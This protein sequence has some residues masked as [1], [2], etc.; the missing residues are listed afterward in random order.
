LSI[1]LILRDPSKGQA[2]NVAG[3]TEATQP[4]PFLKWAGGKRGLLDEIAKRTPFF[5]G[6]YIEPF[7]G[8]GAVFFTQQALRKKVVSDFNSDLMEVYEV[9]RDE[10][11]KL[12]NELRKHRNTSEHFY[13]V[14]DWD[15]RASF[16][17]RSRIGRAA[18]FIFL[19]KTAYNGLYRVNRSGQHNVPFAGQMNPDWV[20]EETIRNVSAFLNTRDL[21]GA[22]TSLLISGDYR[23]SL[24]YATPDS[25]VYLDPP[26]AENFSDYQSEGFTAQD[27]VD[28]RDAVVELTKNKVPFLLSNSDVKQIWDIYQEPKG[29]FQI[30][31]VNVR[32]AIGSKVSSR[33]VISELMINNYKAVGAKLDNLQ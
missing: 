24:S 4:Q 23:D 33:G 2:A 31:K 8:A 27:Q 16:K 11:E 7:L 15:R 19:N 20:Q 30:E 21:S 29:L 12:I 10:P 28:L 3:Q 6:T 22:F 18:R 32:R 17:R 1:K 26:Y 5:T 13:E 25:W 14:R 9:I